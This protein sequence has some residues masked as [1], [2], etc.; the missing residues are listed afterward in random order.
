MALLGPVAVRLRVAARAA[1]GATAA[2]AVEAAERPALLVPAVTDQEQ[3]AELDRTALAGSVA[4][5]AS[6][7]ETARSGHPTQAALLLE[8]EV[9]VAVTLAQ[10]PAEQ[11]AL[12][13]SLEM[14]E[15]PEEPELPAG[16]TAAVVAVEA[17]ARAVAVLACSVLLAAPEARLE[18]AHRDAKE[19]S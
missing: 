18:V 19:S 17:V 15:G 3:L 16:S 12:Q 10:P 9:A 13:A 2:A 5:S 7:V 1:R 11:A 6:A 4:A 14:P 8:P